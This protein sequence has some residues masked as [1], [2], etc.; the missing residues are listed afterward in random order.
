MNGLSVFCR[1]IMSGWCTAHLLCQVIHFQARL[2]LHIN[3]LILTPSKVSLTAD[4]EKQVALGNKTNDKW[5]QY[6]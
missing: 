1:H 3:Q 4:P 2:T 6:H 5:Y